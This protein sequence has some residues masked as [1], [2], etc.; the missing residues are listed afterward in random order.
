MN[1]PS[2]TF[3]NADYRR[4]GD[5]IRSNNGEASEDDLRMLQ[6]LRTSY[7]DPLA[8]IFNTLE[9]MAHRVDKNCICTYRI[10]RIE[11]I[12]SKILR[13]PEMQVNRAEDIAGCR[14]IVASH[15]LVYK[16]Y[17]KIVKSQTKLPFEIKGKVND[18]IKTPKDSGYKSIHLNVTLKNDNRR[19]EIQIR[20]LEDHHWATL[21]EITD[22]LYQSKLKEHGLDFFPELYEFHKLLSQSDRDLKDV[23]KARIARI[24]LKYNYID[25]VGTIFAQN[26]IEVRKRWNRM[27]LQN[28][29]FFL[30]AADSSGIPEFEGFLSFDEAEEAYFSK[31][32]NNPTNKNIVLTHLKYA[33]FAKIS[34]AYSNYFLT[35]NNLMMRLLKT[36]SDVVIISYREHH[37]RD[38]SFFY[39]GFLDITKCW[40]DKKLIEAHSIAEVIAKSKRKNASRIDWEISFKQTHWEY[41]KTFQKTES[42][43]GFRVLNPITYIIRKRKSI[44]FMQYLKSLT[45]PEN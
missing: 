20:S 13:F 26:Y 22:L 12:I 39:Q 19:I 34:C 29:H 25:K 32:M 16:L 17:D 2:R 6:E 4:L 44:A 40:I 1:N 5:R 38:F 21:V 9:R 24:A 14:C 28:K 23:Q 35:Y 43:L 7:K 45:R 37:I 31:Y 42:Q 3:S 41:S 27:L 10:K 15:D 8:E 11:S 33:D 36:I 18:Y 30:V